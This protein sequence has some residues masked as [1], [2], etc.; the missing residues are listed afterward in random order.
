MYLYSNT[1][2]VAVN[3]KPMCLRKTGSLRVF[4]ARQNLRIE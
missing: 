1:I 4:A 3:I 2:V